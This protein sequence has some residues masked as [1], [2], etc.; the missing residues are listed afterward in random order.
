MSNLHFFYGEDSSHQQ[1]CIMDP[2]QLNESVLR[3]ITMKEHMCKGCDNKD[4]SKKNN[5]LKI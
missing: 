2:Y 5:K 3:F 4:M 1:V